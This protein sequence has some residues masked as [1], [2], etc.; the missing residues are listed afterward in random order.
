[1]HRINWG[2]EKCIEKKGGYEKLSK[3]LNVGYE[4]MHAL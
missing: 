2:Y 4:I 1:M 3:L